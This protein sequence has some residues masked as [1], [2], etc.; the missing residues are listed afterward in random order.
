[1]LL[2]MFH[3]IISSVYFFHTQKQELVVSIKIYIFLHIVYWVRKNFILR[4]D[5]G[6]V[7][8]YTELKVLDLFYSIFGVSATPPLSCVPSHVCKHLCMYVCASTQ[9]SLSVSWACFEMFLPKEMSITF[10]IGIVRF[11]LDGGF[12]SQKRLK[13]GCVT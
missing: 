3:N 13:L 4:D 2:Y 7:T 11:Y 12:S 10:V 9:H 8:F 5:G 1:M 6:P